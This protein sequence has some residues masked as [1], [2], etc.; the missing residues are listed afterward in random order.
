MRLI[1]K[2]I[3]YLLI[4]IVRI[5]GGNKSSLLK[6]D[7]IFLYNSNQQLDPYNE[8]FIN[9]YYYKIYHTGVKKGMIERVQ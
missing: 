7:I 1:A 9:D 6:N 5:T 4:V 8:L 2:I 3:Y